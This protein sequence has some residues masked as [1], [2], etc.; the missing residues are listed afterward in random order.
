MAGW[1]PFFYER[2]QVE[3]FLSTSLGFLF[4]LK[5][6]CNTKVNLKITTYV[7]QNPSV[8]N[9]RYSEFSCSRLF[10]KTSRTTNWIKNSMLGY[11]K[12]K[13][14]IVNSAYKNLS[15]QH[16]LTSYSCRPLWFIIVYNITSTSNAAKPISLQVRK[17]FMS[18]ISRPWS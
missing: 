3:N 14:R 2:N 1:R 13:S 15:F 6:W 18:R 12:K 16:S 10:N 8:H 9:G 17:V 7:F 11:L 5:S 4:P